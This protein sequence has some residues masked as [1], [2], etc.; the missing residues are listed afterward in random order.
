MCVLRIKASGVQF[1]LHQTELVAAFCAPASTLTHR[2]QQQL[3]F[4]K[5]PAEAVRRVR[6]VH[7]TFGIPELWEKR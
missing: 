5:C 4:L 3:Q 1:N 6:R 2:K 7:V